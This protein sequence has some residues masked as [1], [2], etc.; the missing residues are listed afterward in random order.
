MRAT[1]GWRTT[2]SF[3]NSVKARPRTLLEDVARFAQAALVP[4]G[5]V[6]LGQVAGDDRLGADAD[7][8]QEHLHLLRRRVLRLVEDDEGVVE[9]A[10]AHEGQ[11]R[12]LDRVLFVAAC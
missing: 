9:R 12:D 5:Q 2:S 8:R 6:D 4:L 10:P 7:A 11:R 3:K 1:S